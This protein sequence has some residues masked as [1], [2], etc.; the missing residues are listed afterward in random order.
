MLMDEAVSLLVGGLS[1]A[2]NSGQ[3]FPSR[4]HWMA[5]GS[6]LK[7]RSPVLNQGST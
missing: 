6:G 4:I 2:L 5:T 1:I 3:G 7:G